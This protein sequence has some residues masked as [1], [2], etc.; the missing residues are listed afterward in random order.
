MASQMANITMQIDENTTHKV[1]ER[2][3]GKKDYMPS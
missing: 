2:L 3:P 1:R